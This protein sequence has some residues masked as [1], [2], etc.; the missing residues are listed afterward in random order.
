MKRAAKWVK[1][2]QTLFFDLGTFSE[3]TRFRLTAWFPLFPS[4]LDLGGV[5]GL[6]R[7]HV[8]TSLLT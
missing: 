3:A 7:G 8:V 4:V 1:T 6:G 2:V 5:E